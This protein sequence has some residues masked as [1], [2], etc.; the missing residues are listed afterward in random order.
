MILRLYKATSLG[1]LNRVIDT[2]NACICDELGDVGRETER[3]RP[4]CVEGGDLLPLLVQVEFKADCLT[5]AGVLGDVKL[6]GVEA[7]EV[8]HVLE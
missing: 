3:H 4:V 2:V 1:D 7:C 8:A 5:D 6:V